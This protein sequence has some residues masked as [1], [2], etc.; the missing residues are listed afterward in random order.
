MPAKRD[1]T[2]N[3][4]KKKPVL[5][6]LV[7]EEQKPLNKGG[8][9]HG[10]SRDQG[11]PDDRSE[12]DVL[13]D[14]TEDNLSSTESDQEQSESE[15]VKENMDEVE[16]EDKFGDDAGE[17]E[18]ENEEEGG[19]ESEDIEDEKVS[20][21]EDEED[22]AGKESPNE[23]KDD[24][25]MYRFSKKKTKKTDDDDEDFDDDDNYFEESNEIQNNIYV[26]PENRITKPIMTKYERVRILGERARQLSLGAKP[27]INGVAHMDPK[28]V[29]K[30]EL[31]MKVMP[32]F[33]ERQLPAGQKER[34]KVSELKIVN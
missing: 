11:D 32:F 23:D 29:A 9:G 26:T 27:M 13:S 17:I 33:I 20:D 14:Q 10:L 34:W 22:D 16:D 24:D 1:P 31:K 8:F 25:C 7:N 19:N 15:D 3:V 5:K 28:E 2:D 4:N 12:E 21:K 30:L 6:K 18:N